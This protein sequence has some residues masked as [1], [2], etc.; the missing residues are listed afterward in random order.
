[1]CNNLVKTICLTIN[2]NSMK[3]HNFFQSLSK[4]FILILNSISIKVFV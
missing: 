1:M 2:A 4:D 3:A